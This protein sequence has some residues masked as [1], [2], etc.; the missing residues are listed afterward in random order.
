M[1][2]VVE[3]V[4]GDM[5]GVRA[6]FSWLHG[7]DFELCQVVLLKQREAE[8]VLVELDVPTAV[9]YTLGC[10]VQRPVVVYHGP[11][12]RGERVGDR[13]VERGRQI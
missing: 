12:G 1:R 11:V 6:H 5:N 3:V 10:R 7:S 9:S 4:A 2:L 13:G 8:P